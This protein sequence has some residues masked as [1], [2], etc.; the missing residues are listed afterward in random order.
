MI[1]IPL[2]KGYV[3]IVDD[4]DADLAESKWSARIKPP[5]VYAF[6]VQYQPVR[7]QL[8]MHRVIMERML[9]AEINDGRVCDHIDGDGLNNRRSNLRAVTL[10]QNSQNRAVRSDSASGVPGVIWDKAGKCWCVAIKIEGRRISL[11]RYRNFDEAVKVREY[12]E[13]DLFGE[14]SRLASRILGK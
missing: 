11:G 3:A 9:G 12:A 1:E 10:S 13:L 2:S 8:V 14:Y 6:R 4:E 7:K 5:G